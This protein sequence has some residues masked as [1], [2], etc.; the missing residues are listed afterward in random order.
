[1]SLTVTTEQRTVLGDAQRCWAVLWLI[2]LPSKIGKQAE[3]SRRLG[4]WEASI[5][6]YG[7]SAGQ[8]P[9][10][11]DV[12]R[13][14]SFCC[15]AWAAVPLIHW[16]GAGELARGDV[17]ELV[18]GGR[19]EGQLIEGGRNSKVDYVIET[20]TGRMTIAR[21][22]VARVD[23]TSDAKKEYATLA[24][25]SPDTADAH[26]KL[27]EWCDA[28]KLREEGQK[29]LSRTL[30]LD[31]DHAEARAELGFRKLKDGQWATRDDVMTARGMVKY[32]GQ[33]YTRQHVEL[34]ER[35][36]A[37]KTT[38]VDWRRDLER[39][40]NWLTG[41]YEDRARQARQ[42]IQAI[43]D[44]LAA[45]PLV[46]MLRK[47]N[48]PALQKLWLEV[49]SRLDSPSAASA[50]IDHSL[51]DSNEEIRRQCLEYLIASNRPG[52]I[53]P[54]LQ[55]LK[56][57]DNV[58]VN[59]AATALGLIGDPAAIGPL[60]D[61]L[62]TVQKVKVGDSAGQM[63]V[64]MAPGNSGFGMSGAPKIVKQDVRNPDVL[65]AL[66]TLTRITGFEYDQSAWR[67]WLAEQTKKQRIDLRRDQ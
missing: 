55:A 12:K 23:A 9:N 7:R 30:E 64:S 13:P 5:I 36:K 37:T 31:P 34:L 1:V 15:I 44:P 10:S 63:S 60:I 11:T 42:E 38:Q 40:R 2:V 66:V 4:R 26:W 43:R 21:S 20:A 50:M 59:R 29:H 27:Y 16:L 51:N 19:V 3:K 56:S 47:E 32:D 6:K 18:N 53:G 25:S 57:A 58:I 49:L 62:V 33:Y 24:K 54:Y 52:L 8:N 35:Q 28:H 65:S 39:M 46:I 17:L 61:V 22:Q 41:R 48:E 45:E 14:A 67:Y